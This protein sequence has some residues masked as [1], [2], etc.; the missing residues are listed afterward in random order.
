MTVLDNVREFIIRQSPHAVCD[1]CIASSLGLSVRQHA[2]HK[3][4]DLARM[5][6]FDRRNDA[7]SI[8]GAEKKVIRHVEG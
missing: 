6:E 8:C 2:N 5:P 4:L 7:C 3:T 1:D